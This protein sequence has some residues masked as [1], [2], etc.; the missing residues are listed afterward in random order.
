MK[1][2]RNTISR[3]N[4]LSDNILTELDKET[5]S[6]E[7]I[8]EE[9]NQREEYLQVLNTVQKNQHEM[10]LSNDE[11]SILRPLFDAFISMNTEI[12]SRI[13]ALL[14]NQM[15]KLA[16]ATKQ[17]KVQESYG[18]IKTPNISYF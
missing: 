17:R 7:V 8:R 13:S 15:E 2:L 4:E 1:R 14:S 12:Q 18:T 16:V 11:I 5:P 10:K 3:L 6:L 9:M